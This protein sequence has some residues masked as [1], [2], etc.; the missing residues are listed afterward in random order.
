MLQTYD[1]RL[2]V[3]LD[4][5]DEHAAEK[6]AEQVS[7]DLC[8]LKIGKELFARSGPQLV[9]RLV[10][11]GYDVFL[12]LKYHDIPA[13]VSGAIS[14]SADLGVWMVN[15]HCSGGTRMLE[16]AR[17]TLDKCN[18]DTLLI[19]VTVLTSMLRSDLQEVG[20]DKDPVEQVALLAALAAK[21]GLDGVVCSPREANQIKR[22]HGDSLLTITPGIRPASYVS[23]GDDQ[24]RTSTPSEAIALGASYLV[25]G[26]PVTGAATP[27][28]A[29]LAIK[30]E[31]GE[32]DLR[33]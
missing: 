31:I 21:T 25:I 10:D 3:A 8:K 7:P 15:V 19:G 11:K 4:Y 33:D 1:S 16:A 14:A 27:A 9:R 2:I 20:I 5:A 18:V 26:R 17:E 28:Q 23:S 13:T 24:R 29:L 30:K 32:N 6:F 12:D 22:S